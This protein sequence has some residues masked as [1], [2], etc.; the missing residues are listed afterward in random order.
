MNLRLRLPRFDTTGTRG[1]IERDI[2]VA[3]AIEYQLERI[4]FKIKIE[5]SKSMYCTIKAN[6]CVH[7][8]DREC[9]AQAWK[10]HGLGW[11]SIPTRLIMIPSNFSSFLLS[12]A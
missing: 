6:I 9:L 4:W 3:N 1:T 11:G 8:E 10:L 2:D 7:A 5:K 12:F